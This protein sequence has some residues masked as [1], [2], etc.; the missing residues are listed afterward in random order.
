M[1]P[2]YSTQLFP[3]LHASQGLEILLHSLTR[4]RPPKPNLAMQAFLIFKLL[5]LLAIANGTPVFA[6]KILGDRFAYPLDGGRRR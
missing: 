6:K 1:S 3:R 2:S 5:I 4:Q